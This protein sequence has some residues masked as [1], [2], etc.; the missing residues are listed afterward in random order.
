MNISGL[1]HVCFVGDGFGQYTGG[2]YSHQTRSS[3][4]STA[5]ETQPQQN[6]N[7]RSGYVVQSYS[8]HDRFLVKTRLWHTEFYSSGLKFLCRMQLS[9]VNLDGTG[10]TLVGIANLI[11]ACPHLTS[12][13][14]SQTHGIPPD[15]QSDDDDNGNNATR[16]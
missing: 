1:M 3:S 6:Q 15:Q 14:A 4:L 9:Q 11:S 13:R 2:R 5:A 16:S 7:H 10:V 12:V 8:L